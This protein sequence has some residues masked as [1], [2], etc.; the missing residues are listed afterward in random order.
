MVGERGGDGNCAK[1]GFHP[2]RCH[3]LNF[4]P[5][6]LFAAMKVLVRWVPGKTSHYVNGNLIMEQ[7]SC[8]RKQT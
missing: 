7:I 8:H 3:W 4:D 6:M 5:K 2:L 1:T